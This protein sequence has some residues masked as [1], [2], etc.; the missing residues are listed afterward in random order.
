VESV[1]SIASYAKELTGKSLSQVEGFLANL[2]PKDLEK[3]LINKG[4]LGVLIEKY[5]FHIN[6]A[7]SDN[8]DFPSAGL[9]LKVTPVKL[10]KS[11]NSKYESK[12]RLSL[13][14]IDYVDLAS[15]SWYES[16][17]LNKCNLM[18][19]LVYLYEKEEA[20]INRKFVLNPLLLQI[21]P[22]AKTEEL[23][24]IIDVPLFQL[25]N[26][27]LNQIKRDWETIRQKVLDG[28]AHELSE[29]D[30][31]YLCAAVKGAGKGKDK[32]RQQPFSS[33]P[34]KGRVFAFKQG[35]M[36]SL[37]NY[38]MEER[39]GIGIKENQTL[40]D[41][42]YQKI[43]PFLGMSTEEIEEKFGIKFKNKIPKSY[44]YLLINRILTNSDDSAVEFEK[45]DIITK[46]IVLD[47]NGRLKESM[48]FKAFKFEEIIKEEWNDDSYFYNIVNSKFFFVVFKKEDSGRT[49]LRNA[50]FWV[51]DPKD[52]EE[53]ER[54]WAETKSRINSG[55][56]PLPKMAESKVVHV[57][58]HG[59]NSKDMYP[60]P[61]GGYEKKQCFW[62]NRSFI[63]GIVDSHS[64]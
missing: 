2:N 36:K 9:E 61:G 63:Q 30:T 64:Q 17:L 39:S 58:P 27:D 24:K 21:Q 37:I 54:V 5:Y 34:A 60:L 15:Q 46:T 18:L 11:Q 42:T 12:E 62:F 23:K 41:A 29:G 14:M 59:R 56:R 6:P 19:I 7:N 47:N 22:D 25:N 26:E 35:F 3:E 4:N 38:H 33:S 50:F 20:I 48:S 57:R 53:A 31:L 55:V 32:P 28:K 52:R 16:K 13:T 44:Y 10:K 51:M 43:K 45:G 8:P 1:D 49:V 40:E